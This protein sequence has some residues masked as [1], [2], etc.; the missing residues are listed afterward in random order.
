[1]P[2]FA[3]IQFHTILPMT[4]RKHTVEAY[5]I[6]YVPRGYTLKKDT[7]W[8]YKGLY[9]KLKQFGINL[10]QAEN[11]QDMWA[12]MSPISQ[13]FVLKQQWVLVSETYSEWQHPFYK[14]RCQ[15]WEA[16]RVRSLFYLQIN[17]LTHAL[18]GK[19]CKLTRKSW[20]PF[21]YSTCWSRRL[22]WLICLSLALSNQ[23]FLSIDK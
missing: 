6:L 2:L 3:P 23:I 12:L 4:S 21:H 10:M 17:C 11:E 19:S 14:I 15:C 1:M 16:E 22:Q 7:W 8:K 5:L 18:Y 9:C 20:I 13:Y